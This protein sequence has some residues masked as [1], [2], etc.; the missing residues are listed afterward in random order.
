M[1]NKL[2]LISHAIS[3]AVSKSWD[4]AFSQASIANIE[5]NDLPL[6]NKKSKTEEIQDYSINLYD[7]SSNSKDEELVDDSG[8][9]RQPPALASFMKSI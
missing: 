2:I 5:E 7:G 6:S 9:F 4:E 3:S 8:G 1:T